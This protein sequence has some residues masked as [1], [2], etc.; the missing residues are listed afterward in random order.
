MRGKTLPFIFAC[1][2]SFNLLLFAEEKPEAPILS[3]K[4]V[5]QISIPGGVNAV[6]YLVIQDKERKIWL[7]KIEGTRLLQEAKGYQKDDYVNIYGVI[8]DNPNARHIK[9]K[10]IEKQPVAAK[11]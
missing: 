6:L 1:F 8:M 10:K 11:K 7:C 3:G 5:D 2:F 9:I 4:I